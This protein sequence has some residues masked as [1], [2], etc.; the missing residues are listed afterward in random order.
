MKIIKFIKH[1]DKYTPNEIAGVE[2]D[3]AERLIKLCVAET[4]ETSE[5]TPKLPRKR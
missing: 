2:D 5:E 1:Y 3:V 4:P